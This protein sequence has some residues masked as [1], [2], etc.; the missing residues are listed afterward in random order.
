M[1]LGLFLTWFTTGCGAAG[2]AGM[3]GTAGIAKLLAGG[4]L[5]PCALYRANTVF[6][7]VDGGDGRGGS[8]KVLGGSGTK[9]AASKGAAGKDSIPIDRMN[10]ETAC[11]DVQ[12]CSLGGCWARILPNISVLA[13][14]AGRPCLLATRF[15]Y[16]MKGCFS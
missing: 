10:D 4:M 2:K 15:Q 3:A 9:G 16:C 13:Q 7:G 14:L 11:P 6:R 12:S 1:G 5:P 8:E